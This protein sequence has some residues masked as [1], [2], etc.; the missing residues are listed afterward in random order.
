MLKSC[1]LVFFRSFLKYKTY[2]LINVVG[3]A[4]GLACIILIGLFVEY[5]LSYD[6]FHE[7]GKRIYRVLREVQV[8]DQPPLVSATTSGPL[9]PT[10]KRDF[11]DVEQMIR[12]WIR[13]DAWIIYA[14]QGSFEE[15][16]LTDPHFF[17]VF[18]FPLIKGDPE[19]V[20][21]EHASIVI[22]QSLAHKYFGDEDPI[23]KMIQAD[24]RYFKG[25]YR[26]TGI[27][28]DI[29]GHSTLQFNLLTATPIPRDTRW[30]WE[31]W[32]GKR[33]WFPVQTYIVLPKGS[34][35][36]NLE[37]KLPEF[38]ARYLGKEVASYNTYYL[39]LF[40]RIYLYSFADYGT[41][42][43]W[44]SYLP[45]YG[46]INRLFLFSIVTFFVLLIACI[47]FMNL[48]TARSASRMQEVG[49]RKVVGANKS[50]LILQF[51]GESVFLSFL[52]L[53]L[54]I[55]LVE[56]MLPFLNAL[57][58]RNL[59]MTALIHLN[60]LVPILLLIFTFLV[61]LLAGSYPAFYLSS[62]KP[63]EILKGRFIG[64][65]GTLSRKLLVVCQFTTSIVLII[66]TLVVYQQYLF[67]RNRALG[68]DKEHLVILP[69]FYMDRTVVREAQDELSLKYETVKQAFLQ[70]PQ[71]DQI[72]AFRFKPG[73][74]GGEQRLIHV[75]NEDRDMPM[76]VQEADEDFLDV[77]GLDLIAGRDFSPDIK[78]DFR[79][80][81]ILNES[82]V[83]Q[84]GWT[85]PIGKELE[86]P[87][88]RIKGPVIGVVKDFH[89]RSL[90]EKIGPFVMVWQPFQFR[91]IGF[92][93]R[94]EAMP[95]TVT[96]LKETWNHFLP[97][98]NF[99]FFFLDEDFDQLYRQEM[100]M[101]KIFSV[102]ALLA[103]FVACLGLFG[104]VAFMAERRTKEI[105]IRKVMG[106]SVLNLM[107]FLSKE[108]VKLVV[109]ANFI[110]WPIAYY[111]MD[112]WLQNYAYRI[113]LGL[114]IFIVSGIIA[115]VI[116]LATVSYQAV[117]AA[118]ANPVDALRHQ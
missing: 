103:I 27:M 113:H 10:L 22:S 38:M 36:E 3:L 5:E 41:N 112:N 99:T 69:I 86:W 54:A 45:E 104:L 44:S 116:S 105:G 81:F 43:S 114:D 117:K 109:I 35:S 61:G 20:L 7:R 23:G 46:N 68:F 80:A 30:Y 37:R 110:A 49:L 31:N 4:V 90:H 8:A 57:T 51:L 77:F 107:L 58:N 108:Y 15:I 53:L 2:S 29:P 102:F 9:G 62:F 85:D 93:I 98:R 26:I 32:V 95:E 72:T 19:T 63:V 28:R 59:S 115:L 78:G 74:V 11:P 70:H 66:C 50:Q 13:Q 64:D 118:T 97:E 79:G 55:L 94:P 84:L 92:K 21:Q 25:E 12:V 47:N 6:R 40:N 88:R 39:Q 16:C 100:E 34:D 82:A 18:T 42:W 17:N 96:F 60:P 87:S 52:A 75:T 67:M 106:A 1:I 65:R 89:N 48:A 111:A 73:V 71:I 56:M 91:N 33:T 76:Q 24:S 101:V 14:Q 83:K